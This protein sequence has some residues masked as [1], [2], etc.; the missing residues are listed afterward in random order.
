MK[1]NNKEN[2]VTAI[3]ILGDNFLSKFDL[4]RTR[5]ACYFVVAWFIE[6]SMQFI[7]CFKFFYLRKIASSGVV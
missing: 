3:V 5:K 2:S 1:V 4:K 7:K 6:T